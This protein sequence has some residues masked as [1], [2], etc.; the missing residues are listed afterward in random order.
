M[1]TQEVKEGAD[2]KLRHVDEPKGKKEDEDG[3]SKKDSRSKAACSRR[4][5][6][7][8]KTVNENTESAKTEEKHYFYCATKDMR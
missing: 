7:G 5:F 2:K 8:S 1:K 3:I 4:D 6:C